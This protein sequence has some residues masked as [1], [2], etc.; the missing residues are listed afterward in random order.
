VT[1]C[2][3]F[4]GTLTELNPNAEAKPGPWRAGAE[5]MI[6]S[7]VLARHRIVIFSARNN[8]R[9]PGGGPKGRWYQ[10]MLT[11]VTATFADLLDDGSLVV[12]DGTQGKPIADVYFDDKGRGV[13]LLPGQWTLT[14]IRMSYGA[15]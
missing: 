13:G 3:D 15:N 8:P 9:M 11:M 7:L 5:E 2:F 6:R 12:D 14:K 4:D 1:A 10:A